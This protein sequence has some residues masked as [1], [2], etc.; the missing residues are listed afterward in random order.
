MSEAVAKRSGRL[1]P[2]KRLYRTVM[3]VVSLLTYGAMGPFGY[4][5]FTLLAVIPTR[6]PVARAHRL[7]GIM[8]R[9]FALLHH[10]MRWVGLLDYDPRSLRGKVPEG[11]CIVISNHPA[12]HDVTTIMS[13][14]PRLCTA[15]NRRTF[16]RWWLRP[17]LEQ[18]GQ[19]SGGS[20]GLLGTGSVL[21]SAAER[22]RQDFRVLVFPEGA[23]SPRGQLRPFA[24]GAFEIA[25]REDVPIVPILIRAEPLWLTRGD[26]FLRPPA[27]LP[28]KRLEVLR[29]LQPAAF[30]HDSRAMRD[31][32]EAMYSRILDAPVARA[33]PA[34]A[35]APHDR[36]P[37][38]PNPGGLTK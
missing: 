5:A 7:Q 32:A 19:F 15:V 37:S 24:R 8:R 35:G 23:R 38:D 13:A 1:D 22:L 36:A 16:H 9:A 26:R 14:V 21:E 4:V 6:D 25:C 33:T 28:A 18:A 17:L 27:E 11:R 3:V 12:L 10:W 34:L 29:T 20:H 31:Y 30:A 2:L